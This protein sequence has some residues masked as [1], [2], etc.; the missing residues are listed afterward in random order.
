MVCMEGNNTWLW[1]EKTKQEIVNYVKE[2]WTDM[3][4]KSVMD[5]IDKAVLN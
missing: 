3:R 4:P 5:Q 1:S 2:V